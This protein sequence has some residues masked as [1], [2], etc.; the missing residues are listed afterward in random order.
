MWNQ[1]SYHITNVQENAAIPQTEVPNWDVY[2]NFRT[3]VGEAPL[4]AP[5][6]SA[7][8]MLIECAPDDMLRAMVRIGSGGRLAVSSATNVSF[9]DGDP[10]T[11]GAFLASASAPGPL[12]PDRSCFEPST[13]D[14]A[15]A[16]INISNS[17]LDAIVR[18]SR[19]LFMCS[20]PFVPFGDRRFAR[21][22]LWHR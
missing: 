10:A 13:C 6:L 15:G 4:G 11:G 2:N 22:L 14:E 12:L 20:S 17:T 3:Q 5:D 9:Y 16:A 1:H 21:C 19:V 7:S 18:S 8:R